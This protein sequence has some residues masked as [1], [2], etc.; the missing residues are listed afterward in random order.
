MSDPITRMPSESVLNWFIETNLKVRIEEK[1]REY[2]Q[3]M[4]IEWLE[5]KIE[6]E[7]EF[8]K[9]CYPG[10]WFISNV[11]VKIFTDTLNEIRG[12]S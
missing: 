8:Q 11:F 3:D 4:F 10:E 5:E 12:T 2:P 9:E 7:K 1:R 6:I